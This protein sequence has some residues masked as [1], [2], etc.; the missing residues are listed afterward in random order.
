MKKK[1]GAIRALRLKKI[2]EAQAELESSLLTLRDH[3]KRVWTGNSF[4]SLYYLVRL[5]RASR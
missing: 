4:A 1:P 5:A 2:S 3:Y